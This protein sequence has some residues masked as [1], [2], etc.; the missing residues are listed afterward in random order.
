MSKLKGSM[1]LAPLAVVLA[2]VGGVAFG[3]AVEGDAG[4]APPIVTAAECPDATSAFEAAGIDPPTAYSAECPSQ[5]RVNELIGYIK[6]DLSIRAEFEAT[7]DYPSE[8]GEE[9][10]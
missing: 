2:G 8:E 4:E 9:S 3:Q 5:E 1:L 6:E 7:G 10:K